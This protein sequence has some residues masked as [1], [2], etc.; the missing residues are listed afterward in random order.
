M[1]R[2]EDETL[3]LA[4]LE[5][6]PARGPGGRAS[7]AGPTLRSVASAVLLAAVA[8]TAILVLPPVI[9]GGAFLLVAGLYVFRTALFRWTTMLILLGCVVMFIP[10][11]RYEIPIPLPF[12][13]E[14]Y[15]LVIGLLIVA[16]IAAVLLNPSF[17]WRPV[18]FGWPIGIF[19]ATQAIS[20]V[21]NG[22]TLVEKHLDL[23]S[24]SNL[25][26]LVF[27]LS[28]FFIVRQMLTR[29]R[30]VQIFLV[31]LTWAGVLV[32]LFAILERFS[33]VNV[34][35][36]LGHVLPLAMLNDAGG[37]S[38]R[39]GGNRAFASAQH[40]IALSVALAMII[41]IAVYLAAHGSWPRNPISRRIVYALGVAM[42]LGGIL[43]AVSRTGIVMLAVMLLTVLIL[44]P[45]LGAVIVALAFPFVVLAGAVVPKLVNSTIVSLFDFNSL[46]A[47]QFSNPG[48]RG[49]GRLADL[50]PA[51]TDFGQAPFF[52]TGIGSRVVVGPYANANILDNQ[53]LG[54]L[55]ETGVLGVV[56]LAVFLLIPIIMLIVF[57]FRT[58]LGRNHASLALA[59]AVSAI[60]Y[61]VAMFFYDA[62][63]FVQSFLILMM[64][65]AVGAWLLTEAAR[66]DPEAAQRHPVAV[67]ISP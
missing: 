53:W 30:V 32:A 31:F 57:V 12:A 35:L 2:R 7:A 40:P 66:P 63:A 54:T 38:A 11:R 4:G 56:G 29:E 25:T 51:L 62:F 3:P 9:A 52:G 39:A 27:L 58:S 64:L 65:F 47:S 15:R 60:G 5:I 16:V 23:A 42:L 34:F 50:G 10:V 26:Q 18:A 14:P 59:I 19:L 22:P 1:T 46:I 48:Y 55:L 43:C 36:L 21:A 49:Q 33:R 37:E 61:A 24:I 6:V 45:R 20:I 67:E 17:S 8:L 13:L 44:R 41:P 28:V